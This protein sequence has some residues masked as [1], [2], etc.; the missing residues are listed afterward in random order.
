[1][2]KQPKLPRLRPVNL[3]HAGADGI[4]YD[5]GLIEIEKT[6]KGRRRLDT[7]IHEM[8]HEMCPEWTESRVRARTKRLTAFLW[9]HR[10]RV[11]ESNSKE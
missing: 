7:L 3:R 6:L 1:M 8:F 5:T 4:W 10:V 2:T 11:I 9:K